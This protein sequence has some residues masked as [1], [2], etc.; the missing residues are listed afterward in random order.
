MFEYTNED[1]IKHRLGSFIR[2]EVLYKDGQQRSVEELNTLDRFELVVAFLRCEAAKG[3]GLDDLVPEDNAREFLQDAARYIDLRLPKVYAKHILGLEPE[4]SA[5]I[6]QT[7]LVFYF[8]ENYGK[9]A[10]EQRAYDNSMN[11]APATEKQLPLLANLLQMNG[12]KLTKD[13]DTVTKME[14]SA[15]ISHFKEKTDLPEEMKGL[16]VKD[17]EAASEAAD[18]EPVEKATA[19]QQ[20]Y[21][22][23]LLAKYRFSLTK[24][25]EEL[26]KVDASALIDHLLNGT[27]LR[28]DLRSLLTQASKEK[29]AI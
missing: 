6:G 29:M 5:V 24:D 4:T 10:G 26:S 18:R 13:F 3:K 16:I 20:N 15:I 14:A 28:S 22:T 12:M 23:S 7:G 1:T 11:K 9:A 21:L 8:P 17:T 2:D 27:P 25:V 19:K